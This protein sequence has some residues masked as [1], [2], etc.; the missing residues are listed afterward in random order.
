MDS[1]RVLLECGA[2]PNAQNRLMGSTPLHMVAQS[3]KAKLDDAL[4]VV[5]LLVAHGA[6]V[7]LPDRGGT[8]PA[9]SVGLDGD[10]S[11]RPL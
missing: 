7:N 6:D 5:D 3:H 8:L 4:A 10:P 1:V 11:K 2:D 9:N